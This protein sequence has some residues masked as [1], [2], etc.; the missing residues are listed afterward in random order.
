MLGVRG[1][2]WQHEHRTHLACAL[3]SENGCALAWSRSNPPN[4]LAAGTV[5]IQFSPMEE[6]SNKS[7]F[8]CTWETLPDTIRQLE[9]FDVLRHAPAGPLWDRHQRA[10]TTHRVTHVT[11][12]GQNLSGS[13]YLFFEHPMRSRG[14][15]TTRDLSY[16]TS[17][18]NTHTITQRAPQ[19]DTETLSPHHSPLPHLK[20]SRDFD[21][22][23]PENCDTEAHWLTQ[24]TGDVRVPQ[25]SGGQNN[26]RISTENKGARL[27]STMLALVRH[28]K[29]V[30]LCWSL[31][32]PDLILSAW[33]HPCARCWCSSGNVHCAVAATIGG[34]SLS[35]L[36]RSLSLFL[37]VSTFHF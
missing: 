18:Q 23:M 14:K 17:T 3:W 8:A 9:A 7:R 21:V 13:D 25:V 15:G 20:S 30:A 33:S 4:H 5:R 11:C 16:T 26:I 22:T 27:G 34:P 28:R 6:R 29:F 12:S 1:R 32:H 36:T 19:Q 37:A 35:P 10:G 2:P 31:F 24:V